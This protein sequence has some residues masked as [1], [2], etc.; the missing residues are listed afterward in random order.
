MVGIQWKPLQDKTMDW[1]M[2]MMM[3]F[4]RPPFV[5]CQIRNVMNE[6]Q[7]NENIFF[8][9]VRRSKLA[10]MR[11]FATEHSCEN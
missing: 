1:K 2:K 11:E 3:R 6:M 4:P 7:V 10:L 8:A 5:P 9:R